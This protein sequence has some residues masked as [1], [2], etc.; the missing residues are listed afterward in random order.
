[1]LETN[2]VITESLSPAVAISGI[3]LLILG[4]NNRISTVGARLRD[5][6][7]ELR[8]SHMPDRIANIRQ[9]AELFLRRGVL[10]RNA[11]FLLFGAVGMMVFTAFALAIVRLH[12]VKWVNVPAW[13][14]ITGL[15]LLL[16]AVIIETYE[17]ILNVKTL[18]LDVHSSIDIAISNEENDQASA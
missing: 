6:N 14:F 11:I 3:G 9:Q 12:Y 5:L 16:L 18:D 4:L 7:R 2:T 1:M 8:Q 17:T 10:I 13:T 15:I